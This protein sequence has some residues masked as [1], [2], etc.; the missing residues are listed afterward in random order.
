ML[1]RLLPLTPNVNSY[2]KSNI[3]RIA[4]SCVYL[5]NPFGSINDD[6]GVVDVLN[7]LCNSDLT[8]LAV[9]SINQVADN[10]VRE[11]AR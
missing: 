9:K 2:G 6:D 3:V 8:Y 4:R 5:D 7:Q 10:G 11:R 1:P